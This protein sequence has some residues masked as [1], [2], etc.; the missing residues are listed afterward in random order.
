[1]NPTNFLRYGSLAGTV[2]LLLGLAAYHLG[3]AADKGIPHIEFRAD[4]MGPR[5]IEELT[6]MSVPR[7]YAFAWQTMEQALEENQPGLLDGYFTGPAK[8]DLTERV[9]SQIASGLRTRY[10]DRGHRL[11]GIFYSPSGD[12][13]EL[14]DRA[15]L[16]VEVLDGDRV[17]YNQPV[18]TEYL[19]LMTPG[20]DRWFVRQIQAVRAKAP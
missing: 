1:M 7:D 18:S 12:A 20:A 19:V 10:L 2:A 8:D 6:T 14:R 17:I 5:A 4:N 9:H 11:E 16:D 15:E 13:M 3:A